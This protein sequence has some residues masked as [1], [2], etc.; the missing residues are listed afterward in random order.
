MVLP[1]LTAHLDIVWCT[2][3]VLSNMTVQK[4]SQVSKMTTNHGR[5][6]YVNECPG[7]IFEL[8]KFLDTTL[9]AI[10]NKYN[11][12]YCKH[13]TGK[14]CIIRDILA[15][16]RYAVIASLSAVGL[17]SVYYVMTMFMFPT[18]LEV[19][20]EQHAL[21]MI[22][23]A[24]LTG[25]IAVLGGIN[26]AMVVFKI[27]RNRM[28]NSAKSG[29]SAALGGVF[30]AFTPG[31]PACTAPLAVILGAVG[32]LSVFPMQG[33]ELK[34]VSIGVLVFAVYWVAKGLADKS[35]CTIK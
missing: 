10:T 35:C 23:S 26:I 7:V 8:V 21:Q 1:A 11:D 20:G 30:A 5:T 15:M 18:H 24:V 33:L 3:G 29:S 27:R 17:G 2:G 13:M 4:Y 19:L 28:I 32:G 6:L 25:V 34:L 14:L 12:R 9:P 31:C 22:T 16:P